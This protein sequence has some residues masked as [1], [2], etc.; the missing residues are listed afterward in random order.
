MAKA[1]PVWTF[2]VNA[3]RAERTFTGFCDMLRYD[4]A[5][6]IEASPSLIILQT[7]RPPTEGRWASFGLYALGAVKSQY[8]ESAP[9]TWVREVALKCLPIPKGVR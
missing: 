2:A 7:D 9:I 6:V 3:E 5:R 1:K 8:Q 4:Q